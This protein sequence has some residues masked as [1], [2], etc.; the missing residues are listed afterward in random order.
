[1]SAPVLTPKQAREVRERYAAG[2]STYQLAREYGVSRRTI[3]SLVLGRS[4]VDAGG[5]V[6]ERLRGDGKKTHCVRGHELKEPNLRYHKRK[7]A[8]GETRY[9]RECRQCHIDREMARHVRR[10]NSNQTNR[11]G[12]SD[13]PAE[14]QGE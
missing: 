11:M 13:G 1:M 9:Y 4:Y 7:T 10:I 5:P 12:F 6:Q 3:A 14:E 8:R 2:A